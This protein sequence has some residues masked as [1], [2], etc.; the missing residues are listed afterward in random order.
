MVE[1][2]SNIMANMEHA[3][4]R[5]KDK[6]LDK[7]TLDKIQSE[8]RGSKTL[9]EASAI[10]QEKQVFPKT[11]SQAVKTDV[12]P[13][14]EIKAENYSSLN[15]LLRI[16]VYTNRFIKNLKKVN[17][18]RG[19]STAN[20]I[21]MA[22]IAWIK[23]LQIKSYID[24]SKGEIVLNKSIIKS[25]LNPNIGN[26]GLIRCY[27][28]LSNADLAEE[29]INPIL[30]TTR[31]KVVELL[32]E[33]HHKKTFHAGVNHTLAQVRMKYWIPKGQA[34]V[35]RVLG[36]CNVCQ[37]YQGGPFKMLS[38]S[39]WPSNKVMRSLP[40]QYTGLDYFAPLY[41]KRG[42]HADRKKSIGVLIYL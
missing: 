31:E 27:G 29:T 16:T 28:R 36:K 32:I 13:P 26:D 9:Y 33:D 10:A 40:F 42:N 30:L 18:T 19:V 38:M 41:I 7:K 17:T 37:K 1:T 15:K 21:E 12:T 14:L 22:N 25:Q 11:A 23:Y 4:D 2:R 5:Q 20:E 24:L 35:K 6:T 34:E 39:P 3:K 8:V